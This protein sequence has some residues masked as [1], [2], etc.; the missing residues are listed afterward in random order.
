VLIFYFDLLDI[1]IAQE[2]LKKLESGETYTIPAEK[3]YEEL[4]L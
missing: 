1:K 3:V 4:K 2:P